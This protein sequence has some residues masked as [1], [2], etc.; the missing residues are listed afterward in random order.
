M[1]NFLKGIIIGMCNVIPGLCSATVSMMFRM[2]DYLLEAINCL[3]KPKY[4]KKYLFFYISLIIGIILGV[5][6][7]NSLY[8]IIP[9]VLSCLFIGFLVKSFPVKLNN[10]ES[11]RNIWVFLAGMIVVVIFSLLNFNIINIDYREINIITFIVI[12]INGLV[13]SMAMILPGLSGALMLVVLGLY[14]PLLQAI[15]NIIFNL[16]SLN[17]VINDYILVGCFMISFLVGLIISSK[18]IKKLIV[19]FP[20]FMTNLVNGMIIGSL[21]NLLLQLP[22]NN[23]SIMQIIVGLIVILMIIIIP[24]KIKQ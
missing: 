18:A 7:L 3:Y 2:Y 19:K 4:W 12:M 1:F 11:K 9:F 16:C 17:F 8:K 15:E 21:V 5:L 14:F 23:V 10:Q 20:S 22:F 13:S 24:I 6:C